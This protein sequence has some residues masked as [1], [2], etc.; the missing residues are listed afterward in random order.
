[1]LCYD[2]GARHHPSGWDAQPAPQPPYAHNYY[3][4]PAPYAPLAAPG[5]PESPDGIEGGVE[6]DVHKIEQR[7]KQIG[8]GKSTKGY[9]NYLRL[10]PME[11]REP[12]HEEHPSTPRAD[13]KCSKRSWDMQLKNWRR[14]LHR[15]DPPTA[16]HGVDWRDAV[17]SDWGGAGPAEDPSDLSSGS[18][19][20][21]S[22]HISWPWAGAPA[23]PDDEPP[24]CSSPLDPPYV[25][26]DDAA[27]A[28]PDLSSVTPLLSLLLPS[29]LRPAEEKPAT[30]ADE[31]ENPTPSTPTN[32][33]ESPTHGDP[34]QSAMSFL[35]RHCGPV[36]TSAPPS[37]ATSVNVSPVPSKAIRSSSREGTPAPVPWAVSPL[38]AT[39]PRPQL[40]F[41]G[42]NPMAASEDGGPGSRQRSPP[43]A[44]P[45]QAQA[46]PSEPPFWLKRP[47][48]P[49]H[50]PPPLPSVLS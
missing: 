43:L 13:Q 38:E 22:P 10:V 9:K 12:D 25:R 4:A 6:S 27:P 17:E 39:L 3:D 29:A 50:P 33:D 23:P 21:P 8:Y 1:M 47:P 7:L 41:P 16:L 45:F 18:N 20:C 42:F 40:F 19:R 5:V 44:S 30:S 24:R 36:G 15:W 46:S 11:K 35:R 49:V 31:P 48:H 14:L 2:R 26:Q 37:P 32:Q 34:F 28:D